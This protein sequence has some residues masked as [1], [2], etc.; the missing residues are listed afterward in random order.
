MSNTKVLLPLRVPELGPSLGRLLS[1]RPD[2]GIV[3]QLRGTRFKLA[4]RI[5]DAGGEARRLSAG[6]DR[7]ATLA[8]IGREVWKQA[9]DEAV[10]SATEMLS[11]HLDSRLDAEARAVRMSRRSRENLK[12]DN[13]ARPALKARLGSTGAELISALDQ[14]EES[15]LYAMSATGLQPEAVKQWQDN[16]GLAARRLT[17]AW[18]ALEKAAEA[19]MIA[20]EQRAEMVSRWRRPLWPVF[21]VG[22]IVVPALFWF[23]LVL[24]GYI[25]AP[26][27]LESI[28]QMVF[29]P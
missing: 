14:L 4:S 26:A 5:I 17:E 2:E 1:L 18:L 15:A 12:I 13:Q 23:G 27:W 21:V 25:P 19:E 10:S 3:P 8:A 20:G 9:W 24:G 22:I 28:W 11:N 16:L 29:G 6:D 7:P